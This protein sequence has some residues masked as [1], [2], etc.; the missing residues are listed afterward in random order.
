M[1]EITTFISTLNSCKQQSIFWHNQTISYAEH[2][3]LN[4]FY[5]G[6]EDLLDGLVES[7]AG[8]YGRPTGYTAHDFEDYKDKAQLQA[9]FKKVYDF[10]QT[11]RNNVYQETWVQNQIDEIAALVSTTLYFLTLA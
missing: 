3:A 8:I 5:E 7:V 2:K 6:I 11:E 9:Y 1:A 4:N 10:V